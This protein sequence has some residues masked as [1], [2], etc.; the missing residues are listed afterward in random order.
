MED[1]N[2]LMFFAKVVE[3]GG[4]SEAGRRLGVP[5]SRLSRRMAVLE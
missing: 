3:H 4:F 2:D 5:K 1:L